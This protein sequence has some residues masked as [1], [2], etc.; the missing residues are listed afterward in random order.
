[1]GKPTTPNIA[2]SASV[3]A[4]NCD[5]PYFWI[6][7][8]ALHFVE[9]VPDLFQIGDVSTTRVEGT[10]PR[11][12]LREGIDEEFLNTTGVNLEVEFVRD[13]VQP[14]LKAEDPDQR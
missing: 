10:V 11:R 1:M 14:T 5:E 13:G 12:A 4:V 6:D 3:R 7:R 8:G 2:R 9:G